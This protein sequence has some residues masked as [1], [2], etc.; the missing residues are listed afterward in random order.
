MRKTLPIRIEPEPTR[1]IPSQEEVLGRNFAAAFIATQQGI[2]LD[3]AR[4]KHAHSPSESFG[5]RWRVWSSTIWQTR[6]TC[7]RRFLPRSSEARPFLP[8]SRTSATTLPAAGLSRATA[9]PGAN[10]FKP[11]PKTPRLD[12]RLRPSH[13]APRRFRSRLSTIDAGDTEPTLP[14]AQLRCD[15]VRCSGGAAARDA[16][17]GLDLSKTV[18]RGLPETALLFD[19]PHH[20]VAQFALEGAVEFGHVLERGDGPPF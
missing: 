20:G 9:R 18:R 17:D 2:G 3:Y 6:P 12:V 16:A 19:G 14:R 11:G 13:R 5:Y 15:Y 1:P 7:P 8:P 4:R 10:V